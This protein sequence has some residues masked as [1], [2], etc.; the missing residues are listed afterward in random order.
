MLATLHAVSVVVVFA[1]L[2][3]VSVFVVLLHYTLL[4]QSWK[5]GNRKPF[6]P[7]RLKLTAPANHSW[8][9]PHCIVLFYHCQ[10][11]LNPYI[12]STKLEIQKH[13]KSSTANDFHSKTSWTKWENFPRPNISPLEG[14]AQH[15][16][17]VKSL[18]FFATLS[19]FSRHII[20]PL[21][22]HLLIISALV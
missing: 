22:A 21:A 10:E 4:A 9:R 17:S 15:L 11:T 20:E 8:L 7:E 14:R 13:S 6:A 16:K 12:S 18:L 1:T 19:S 2:H 5:R 3:A